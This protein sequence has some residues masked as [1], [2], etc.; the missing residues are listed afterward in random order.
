MRILVVNWNNLEFT[1]QCA[2]DLRDQLPNNKFNVVIVDQASTEEGTELGLKS[3]GGDHFEIVFNKE[4][5]PLNS[6]WNWFKETYDDEILC[7]LNNDVRIPSNFVT[8][9]MKVFEKHDNVGIVVHATNHLS[10]NKKLNELE[11][12]IVE[13]FKYMQGW[14]Y[15]IRRKLWKNIPVIFKT[16]C[17]DDFQ[18]DNV[19]KQGYNLAYVT[20]SPIIHYEGMSKKFMKTS[21][22]EDVQLYIQRGYQHY[23]KIKFDYSNIKP[24]FK[25]IL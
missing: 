4:N 8:D 23:L 6:V 12:T 19:Y 7:F 25:E 22:I 14:D 21:G 3:C 10:Y 20:S 5:K 17:G 11:Y 13:P 1:K 16:Y 15:S 24:T 2:L 18:F 9:T